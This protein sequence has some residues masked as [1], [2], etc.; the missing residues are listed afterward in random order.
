MWL[1]G[2]PGV[3]NKAFLLYYKNEYYVGYFYQCAWYTKDKKI[4]TD[5]IDSV[6]YQAVQSPEVQDRCW[7]ARDKN[8]LLY[9]YISKPIN[10][11][12]CFDLKDCDEDIFD[13]FETIVELPREM[14]SEV[15]F[16]NSPQLLNNISLSD[17]D[18]L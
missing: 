11:G 16:E 2:N 13:D 15:T 17:I 14:Y 4:L 6:Y 3:E 12:G 8:G 5:K 1:K 18:N 10:N 7:I 9:L